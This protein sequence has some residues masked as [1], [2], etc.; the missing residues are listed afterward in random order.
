[1]LADVAGVRPV[2]VRPGRDSAWA[3]YTV[4]VDRR[5]AVQSRLA[6]VGV[7]TAVHYPKPL[8]H[9]AA[10]AAHCCPDCC[11]RSEAAAATVLSLPISADLREEQ[12][13][14][15]VTALKSALA[16]AVVPG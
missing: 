1:L 16:L 10:Y 2:A 4:F 8:H 14:H 7:P 12:Q 15:V 13:G 6:S 5:E 11:P 3:Q 9:Q